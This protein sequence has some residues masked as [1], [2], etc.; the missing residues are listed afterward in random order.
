MNELSLQVKLLSF[1]L[2]EENKTERETDKILNNLY[3]IIKKYPIFIRSFKQFFIE[4]IKTQQIVH[5]KIWKYFLIITTF[6]ETK[7]QIQTLLYHI[8]EIVPEIENILKEIFDINFFT[9]STKILNEKDFL[10]VHV[11]E[12]I[13]SM[14][15]KEKYNSKIGNSL[16]ENFE[17]FSSLDKLK[18][19]TKNVLEMDNSWNNFLKNDDYFSETKYK[20]VSCLIDYSSRFINTNGVLDSSIEDLWDLIILNSNLE[21]KLF[22]KFIFDL[23]IPIILS[24]SKRIPQTVF[25]QHFETLLELASLTFYHLCFAHL[26]DIRFEKEAAVSFKY[27][28][29]FVSK[30]YKEKT[31]QLFISSA[32]LIFNK[33]SHHQKS[34]VFLNE[35]IGMKA[36][37]TF[38]QIVSKFGN[39]EIVI[40]HMC[41]LRMF[42]ISLNVVQFL[43]LK[44]EFDFGSF[45]KNLLS[46]NNFSMNYGLL[47]TIKMRIF[48]ESLKFLHKHV[49]PF[50]SQIKISDIENESIRRLIHVI[51]KRLIQVTNV[52]DFELDQQNLLEIFNNKKWEN[53]V[54]ILKKYDL[55]DGS[56]LYVYL[57][58]LIYQYIPKILQDEQQK[59]PIVIRFFNELRSH[60]TIQKFDKFFNFE[61]IS[62]TF[63]QKLKSINS[64]SQ[65]ELE[66]ELST[67][68]QSGKLVD[69][70]YLTKLLLGALLNEN[71]ES[72]KHSILRF[73]KI[74]FSKFSHFFKIEPILEVYKKILIMQTNSL[75]FTNL[76]C[77]FEERIDWELVFD[78]KICNSI[79]PFDE[80]L[81]H[82]LNQKHFII[83]KK[84]KEKLIFLSL[85]SNEKTQIWCRKILQ[86]SDK[87][88]I[89]KYRQFMWYFSDFINRKSNIE[90]KNLYQIITKVFLHDEYLMNFEKFMIENFLIY[91]EIK[92]KYPLLE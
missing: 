36:M 69:V 56:K 18:S 22:R 5:K 33:I 65:Q 64:D 39:L 86:K 50:F 74:V 92:K 21:L 52:S 54:G 46:Q 60:Y 45:M 24:L 29:D 83:P 42:N 91:Y 17:N 38:T 76:I 72:K 27:Y 37:T 66:L 13:Y 15:N 43:S 12:L 51:K 30:N 57:N 87:D 31:N 11:S 77:S 6:S 75:F 84:L 79:E 35:E 1:E 26:T 14:N 85:V 90:N 61:K 78:E 32:I 3:I 53:V 7:T 67:F 47:N 68:L 34:F 62:N 58:N 16:C 20:D 80:N 8:R 48:S 25:P 55:K 10:F 70:Q 44:K 82:I 19:I 9:L 81:S 28:L 40:K 73:L 41:L 49:L 89:L 4:K 63:V 71:E 23:E 2:F 59:I 88:S